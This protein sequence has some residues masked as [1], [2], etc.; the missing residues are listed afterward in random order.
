MGSCSTAYTESSL[1][2]GTFGGATV[3]GYWDDLYIYSGT[4]QGIYKAVEGNSPNRTAIFEYYTSHF[5][6]SNE[7]YHFQI[8]LYENLPGIVKI[9]YFDASDGGVSCTIGVQGELTILFLMGRFDAFD[10]LF[11]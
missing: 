8:L 10:F 2:T 7:Y 4:S 3:F 1:P 11:I 6:A 9:I 5:G